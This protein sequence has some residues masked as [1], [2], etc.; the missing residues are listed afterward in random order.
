MYSAAVVVL[1]RGQHRLIGFL[2]VGKLARP[3]VFF[4]ERPVEG[5][6]VSVL[7][8]CVDVDVFWGVILSTAID[9]LNSRPVYWDPLS[10]LRVRP[11]S[12]GPAAATALVAGMI[13]SR[14]VARPASTNAGP[15]W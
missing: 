12:S 7:L 4:L 10:T 8:W 9:D 13:A 5:L 15:A 14:R 6:D 3:D 2:H 11:G 1:E